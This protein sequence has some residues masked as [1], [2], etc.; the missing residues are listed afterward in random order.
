MQATHVQSA[1][2]SFY[3]QLKLLKGSSFLPALYV[4]SLPLECEHF[5]LCLK[6]KLDLSFFFLSSAP[7]QMH[8]I[9]N[10][11]HILLSISGVQMERRDKKEFRLEKSSNPWSFAYQLGKLFCFL[12]YKNWNGRSH[13]TSF[14]IGL[15]VATSLKAVSRHTGAFKNLI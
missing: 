6:I 9:G 4:M 5:Q 3:S 10:T 7:W 8:A 14:I 13:H 2:F 15:R 12:M 11:Q 1:F